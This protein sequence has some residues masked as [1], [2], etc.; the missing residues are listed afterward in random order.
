MVYY[1]YYYHHHHHHHHHH[2]LN[3]INL[4][5]MVIY[6]PNLKDHFLHLTFVAVGF[7]V[8][9]IVYHHHLL[10]QLLLLSFNFYHDILVQLLVK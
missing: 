10:L 1:Y 2:Q 3:K 6:F 8:V 5:Y 7:V 4:V 9:L